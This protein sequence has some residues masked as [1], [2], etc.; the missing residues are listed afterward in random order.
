MELEL[1]L[2]SIASIGGL[3]SFSSVSSDFLAGHPYHCVQN[4]AQ[5][6]GNCTNTNKPPFIEREFSLS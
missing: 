5:T 2:I 1:C 4:G 6:T 3:W